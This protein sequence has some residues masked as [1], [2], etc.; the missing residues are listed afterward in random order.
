MIKS[1]PALPLIGAGLTRFQPVFVGDTAA[2][3]LEVSSAPDTAG[4]TYD[5]GGPQVYSFRRLLELLM[6]ALDR[7]RVLITVSF[8]MAEIQA[9]LLGYCL[10]R[11]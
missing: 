9:A 2:G 3:L 4:K 1:S 8:A 6:T 11:R 10:T 7:Q 5:C